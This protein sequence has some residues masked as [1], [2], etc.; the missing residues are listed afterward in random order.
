M[1]SKRERCEELVVLFAHLA[2]RFF[3]LVATTN[4][5]PAGALTSHALHMRVANFERILPSGRTAQKNYFGFLR[6]AVEGIFEGGRQLLREILEVKFRV[7]CAAPPASGLAGACVQ[8]ATR[9]GNATE[10]ND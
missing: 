4:K 3:L 8:H 7:T 6:Y 10:S 5:Q 1:N 9:S 2:R